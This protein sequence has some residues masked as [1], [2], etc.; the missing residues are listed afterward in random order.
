MAY[1]NPDYKTKKEFKQAV[2]SGR[3]VRASGSK[4]WY[5]YQGKVSPLNNLRYLSLFSL[6]P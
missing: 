2:E 1:V 6:Y 4:G 5:R 3:L